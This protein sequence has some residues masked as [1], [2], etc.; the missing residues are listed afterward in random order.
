MHLATRLSAPIRR[1]CD[2]RCTAATFT[3]TGDRD[4]EIG[5]GGKVVTD[6]SV[7]AACEVDPD[8]AVTVDVA[9]AAP[10]LEIDVRV[11]RRLQ[12]RPWQRR[13]DIVIGAQLR[14]CN[15]RG[16]SRAIVRATVSSGL[17]AAIGE[18]A[19]GMSRP[20]R[21]GHG[22]LR[23][24][25]IVVIC[26]TVIALGLGNTTA[27]T[28]PTAVTAP[29]S[30]GNAVDIS[31]VRARIAANLV[32]NGAPTPASAELVTRAGARARASAE[33]LIA[34]ESI[35]SVAPAAP[36]SSSVWRQLGPSNASFEFNGWQYSAVD[37][38]RVNEVRVAPG[39]A[40]T[41]YIGAAG[42]GI[43]RTTNMSAASPTWVPVGDNLPA[44]AVG[45]FDLDP[46]NPQRIIA[47]L[48]D[49]FDSVSVGGSVVQSTDGGA[50]WSAPVGIAGAT[51]VRDLRIDPS[52]PQIVL[53]AA[54]SG[55][56]R[57]GNGG[58]S[59]SAVTLPGLAQPQGWSFAYAGVTAGVS[60]WVAAAQQA[61]GNGTLFRSTDAGNP[62]VSLDAFL[63]PSATR[64]RIKVAA[65]D[66]SG[67]PAVTTMYA[68][69]ANTAGTC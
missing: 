52:N 19:P 59:F 60:T 36:A 65:G 18:G 31:D 1:T 26:A 49:P 63:P 8:V 33:A 3:L 39:G 47:G 20:V 34:G 43:W 17:F 44:L 38:G 6:I 67:G 64:G 21:A 24:S 56:F 62:W 16:K 9:V 29:T 22:S 42:G 28:K 61:N 69:V 2:A 23:V 30:P 5:R 14:R 25:R 41:V 48:G 12:V 35:G 11:L 46:T 45:S 7:V 37:S 13:R 55:V 15:A 27:A 10:D 40:D 68:Q 58:A 66:A 51:N 54:D 57:S 50:T 32:F 4:G 53:V